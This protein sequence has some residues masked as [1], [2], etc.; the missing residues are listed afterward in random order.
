MKSNEQLRTEL[1][2]KHYT[3][4]KLVEIHEIGEYLIVEYKS[5]KYKNHTAV[6][7]EYEE[8]STFHPFINGHDTNTGYHSMDE[9]LAG[10]IAI[11]YE[12]GNSRGAGYFIRGLMEDGV[13][14]PNKNYTK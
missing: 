4:G 1:R 10:A 2:S 9:C 7:G 11:K 5:K 14:I 3:W 13:L 6:N 12:G 8:D